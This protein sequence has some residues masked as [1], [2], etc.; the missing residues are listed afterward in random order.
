L[1]KNKSIDN[2]II[3]FKNPQKKM[4]VRN[5]KVGDEVLV[6]ISRNQG[7]SSS[8]SGV[9]GIEEYKVWVIFAG[10]IVNKDMGN[11]CYQDGTPTGH[12]LHDDD[13]FGYKKGTGLHIIKK[14]WKERA[15][16]VGKWAVRD[17]INIFKESPFEQGEKI[18]TL[19]DAEKINK[20][21]NIKT[22]KKLIK[23]QDLE[24][25]DFDKKNFTVIIKSKALK[26]IGI[27]SVFSIIVESKMLLKNI[28]KKI[29][30]Q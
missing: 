14:I 8:G 15:K 18:Q 17:Y 25:V 20:N 27:T 12:I 7:G 10:F 4:R 29:I 5:L 21:A 2:T 22:D 26:K 19:S 11:T 28:Y 1:D 3:N 23:A 13:I 6:Y 16:D 24:Y 9:E 30:T